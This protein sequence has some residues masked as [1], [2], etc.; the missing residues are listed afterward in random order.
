MVRRFFLA[1]VLAALAALIAAPAALAQEYD[2]GSSDSGSESTES[3]S[4]DSESTSAE[5]GGSGEWKVLGATLS[6]KN[7]KPEAGDP[8]GTGRATVKLKDDQV[9][10]NLSWSNIGAATLGHIH[11]GGKEDA[12]PAVVNFFTKPPAKREGCVEVDEALVARI[13]ANPGNYYVN[14]HN[15]EFPKGAIRGQLSAGGGNLPFTGPGDSSQRLLWIGA[16]VAVAGAGL[17]IVTRRLGVGRHLAT[18]G[19]HLSRR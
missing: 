19:R 7:E 11:R 17:L 8:D 15:Q 18:A 3:A 13:A 6:G 14:I 9:C 1:T 2:Y 16:L 5:S 10:F 4:N 12:G